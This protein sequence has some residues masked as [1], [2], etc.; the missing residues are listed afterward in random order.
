MMMMKVIQKRA[1]VS[2]PQSPSNICFHLQAEYHHPPCRSRHHPH[3][4]CEPGSGSKNLI[5]WNHSLPLYGALSSHFLCV[6]TILIDLLLLSP[7]PRLII[8][9]RWYNEKVSFFLSCVPASHTCGRSCLIVVDVVLSKP[10]R[11]RKFIRAK[12]SSHEEY[13]HKIYWWHSS[14]ALFILR[15]RINTH[16]HTHTRKGIDAMHASVLSSAHW[17]LW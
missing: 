5:S 6:S 3:H 4:R 7:S 12:E 11:R 1:S 15:L 13:L 2:L 17:K 16:T 9:R 10:C 8:T 14:F